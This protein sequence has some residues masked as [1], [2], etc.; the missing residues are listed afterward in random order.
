MSTTAPAQRAQSSGESPATAIIRELSKG[1]ALPFF[2]VTAV[3][4][5]CGISRDVLQRRMSRAG[6]AVPTDM[7][8]VWCLVPKGLAAVEAVRNQQVQA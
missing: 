7:R 2:R 8:G 1:W 3:A 5:S 4:A 6:Y